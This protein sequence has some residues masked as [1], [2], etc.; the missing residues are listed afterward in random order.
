MNLLKKRVQ[1]HLRVGEGDV[2]EVVIIT[3]NPDRV[4]KIASKFKDPEERARYRGLVTYHVYTPKGNP[5]TLDSRFIRCG[6]H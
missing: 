6:F 3:G 1:P 4:P 2:E 5:V